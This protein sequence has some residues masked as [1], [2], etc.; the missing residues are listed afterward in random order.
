[1]EPVD[2]QNNAKTIV[3][4]TRTTNTVGVGVGDQRAGGGAVRT[5]VRAAYVART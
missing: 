5:C 2:V 3:R 1:M 4:L